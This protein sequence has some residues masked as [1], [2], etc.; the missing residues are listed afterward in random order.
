[1]SIQAY[2]IGGSGQTTVP[3]PGIISNRNPTSS[4]I[5]SPS[6]SVYQPGQVWQNVSSNLFFQYFGS[7]NWSGIP[8]TPTGLFPITPT[9]VG[10]VGFA[11]FQTIQSAINYFKNAGPF[12]Q[13]GPHPI[14]IQPGFYVENLDFTGFTFPC[15]IHLRSTALNARSSIDGVTITGTITPNTTGRLLFEDINLTSNSA[16]IITST[17]A[18]TTEIILR[19]CNSVPQSFA[20]GYLLNIPN[21]TNAGVIRIEN[22]NESG[23]TNNSGGIFNTGGVPVQIL[24]CPFF[25]TAT[26][27]PLTVSGITLVQNSNITCPINL[28]TGCTYTSYNSNYSNPITISNNATAVFVGDSINSG[29]SAALIQSSSGAVTLNNVTITSSNNPSISGA[30]AGILS[31]NNIVWT[32]NAAIA[33]T[34]TLAGTTFNPTTNTSLSTGTLS[35]KSTTANPGNNTGFIEIYVNGTLA[36]VPYFV[37]IAP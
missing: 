12:T 30:G 14:Y 15:N 13:F 18:G 4:D 31:L 7:G 9:V 11:G 37:N 1:M 34:L 20:G 10:P 29:A 33:G 8:S 2:E 24:D 19:N 6:G 36:Y 23:P 35:V 25:G 22:H 32:S 5:V 3:S 21:W 17:A 28:V 27:A 16:D 26:G